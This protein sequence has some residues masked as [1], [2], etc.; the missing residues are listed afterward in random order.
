MEYQ[1]TWSKANESGNQSDSLVRVASV[2]E[3][4]SEGCSCCHFCPLL[5][6]SVHFFSHSLAL[7][8]AQSQ[9]LFSPSSLWSHPSQCWVSAA[10]FC[11]PLTS[12]MSDSRNDDDRNM[13]GKTG[14]SSKN[15]LCSLCY[16]SV[17]LLLV[18]CSCTCT[19]GW[20]ELRLSTCG[21]GCLFCFYLLTSVW[22][23]LATY[24]GGN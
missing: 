11:G 15:T 1:T 9:H 16:W 21:D 23:W 4:G 3:A 12:N 14:M 20:Q 5:T 8:S 22:M 2:Q 17:L 6:R 18:L 24:G 10:L 7:E 19:C 13:P